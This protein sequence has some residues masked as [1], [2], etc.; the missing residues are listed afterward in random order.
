L[1]GINLLAK[2]E[3][4]TKQLLAQIFPEYKWIPW[5]FAKASQN[6]WDDVNNQRNYLNWAEKRL[7]IKEM[8]DW[9]N[10]TLAV[11]P[12]CLIFIL[13]QLNRMLRR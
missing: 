6:F 7:K 8:E 4:S 11:I 12:A 3:G 9:Y 5:E 13:N 2:Y 1:G 10:I